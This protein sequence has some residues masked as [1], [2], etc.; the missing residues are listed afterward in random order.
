MI[1]LISRLALVFV[2]TSLT[3]VFLDLIMGW[4]IEAI[5]IALEATLASV[6]GFA[7]S[8]K[9]HTAEISSAK[10]KAIDAFGED[11]IC[12]MVRLGDGD[13]SVIYTASHQQI[14]GVILTTAKN[15]A[16]HKL[17]G[18]LEKFQCLNEKTDDTA[19]LKANI[20]QFEFTNIG[21]KLIPFLSA[22][23]FR[24]RARVATL[25]T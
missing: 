16:N 12:E 3:I 25:K 7:I 23:A 11:I 2:L 15:S 4:P 9:K 19:L 10:L 24:R 13:F 17:W 1:A 20:V 14:N 22:E 5:P 8:G 6:I 21:R 18:L